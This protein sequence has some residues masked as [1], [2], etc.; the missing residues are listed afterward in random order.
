MSKRAAEASAWNE[1]KTNIIHLY[2]TENI[3][4]A[5]VIHLME[6]DFGF[7]RSK[8]QYER[9]LKEWDIKKYSKADDWKFI[10][11]RYNPR[12][13]P[14]QET[15]VELRGK[16]IPDRKVRKEIARQGYQTCMERLAYRPR[17]QTPPGI[18]I[19]NPVDW[20]PILN[21]EPTDPNCES[22]LIRKLIPTTW[23]E[24]DFFVL[25]ESTPW[26]KFVKLVLSMSAGSG[27][28]LFLPDGR[29]DCRPV[30]STTCL[31]QEPKDVVG[32]NQSSMLN[33]WL[34]Y[35][36]CNMYLADSYLIWPLHPAC[37]NPKAYI[38]PSHEKMSNINVHAVQDLST[39]SNQLE[40]L[41]HA[42]N[43]MSN[44]F[45]G[46]HIGPILVELAREKRNLSLLQTLIDQKDLLVAAVLEKLWRPALEA[47][48][49][50]LL[51][52]ILKNSA[53]TEAKADILSQSVG[54]NFYVRSPLRFAIEFGQEEVFEFLLIEG[55]NCNERNIGR[56]I[57]I[58]PFSFKTQYLDNLLEFSACQGRFDMVRKLLLPMPHCRYECPE[59]T[60]TTLSYAILH[61]RLETF[62]LTLA[63]CPFLNDQLRMRPW[64]ILEAAAAQASQEV[65]GTV[66]ALGLDIHAT[67]SNG[68]GSVLA[69]ATL[70]QN[71]E[72][73]KDLCK[74]GVNP[75][76]VLKDNNSDLHSYYFEALRR[77]PP[78]S[79]LGGMSSLHIATM[80]EHEAIVAFLIGNGADVN[81]EC[82]WVFPL[83]IAVY[84]RNHNLVDML[85]KAG[86]NAIAALGEVD[87]TRHHRA[88]FSL[89]EIVGRSSIRIALE[90]GHSGIFE[91]LIRSTAERDSSAIGCHRKN[92]L[93]Y[94]LQGSNREL[95]FRMIDG[96]ELS[97]I[98]SRDILADI[99]LKFGCNDGFRFIGRIQSSQPADRCSIEVLS[100][101]ISQN[102]VDS[103]QKILAYGKTVFGGLS[104]DYCS[105]GLAFACRVQSFDT[106]EIFLKAG[107]IPYH[108]PSNLNTR[109]E[110]LEACD[111]S[112]T[113][114]SFKILIRA[115]IMPERDSDEML[116][117]NNVLH[118]SL[119]MI[120]EKGLDVDWTPPGGHSLLQKA[121]GV[122]LKPDIAEYL[123]KFNPNPN[124]P[125]IPRIFAP[126]NT[127]LQ[128]TAFNQQKS[129]LEQL[130]RVGADPFTGPAVT[131]G[132]TAAQFAAM[133]GNF[134]NLNVL[135]QYG[136]DINERPGKHEGRTAIEGSAEHGRLDMVS[137]L[138]EAG[139][140]IQGKTN[141]NYRRTL[142]RAWQKGHYTIVR[143]IQDW[144]YARYGAED[145]ESIE[146]IM[147]TMTRNELEF[148][149]S[150][151]KLEFEKWLEDFY[152][153]EDPDWMLYDQAK[154]LSF[155]ETRERFL[156]NRQSV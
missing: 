49:I 48:H 155:L 16:M 1:H 59:M 107:A 14:G 35:M 138:L 92:A 55:A 105:T 58:G 69:A 66:L 143:M 61:S 22:A 124:P 104:I 151:A 19:F 60:I 100:A 63:Q 88:Y 145:C 127:A 32:V 133:A 139:A 78:S 144:K 11:H 87:N 7:K 129:L 18:R 146:T 8:A 156:N 137:Y 91:S 96:L 122:H 128:I 67:D 12:A 70:A 6:K 79:G 38:P 5:K 147:E 41:K 72:R 114:D 47:A 153:T 117:W 115:C 76:G 74:R 26:M 36:L 42:M 31:S 125:S 82:N 120:I 71:L 57:P 40:F 45:D 98:I 121:L 52:M 103:V 134:E 140:D 126:I 109:L 106:L 37:N 84:R 152:E 95:I 113:I 50:P 141:T 119:A 39:R 65:F 116:R 25:S 142:Y 15:W 108:A 10:A 30:P 111:S 51:R 77:S 56:S 99:I 64:I 75:I 20:S 23:T 28:I 94:A 46:Y 29:N 154:E 53:S 68:K 17:S 21:I 135:L 2:Q 13:P 131:H 54:P 118:K 97:D 34:D 24:N 132:A 112:Q 9:T 130:L 44:N 62:R 86:A 81:Q 149:S 110:A 148:E 27:D 101:A 102:D 136:V 43:L 83:Q 85:L 80:M 73:I 93:E 90:S 3:S 123:L 89:Q 150:T 4:L 33:E